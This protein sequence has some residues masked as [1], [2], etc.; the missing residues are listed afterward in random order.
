MYY[1]DLFSPETYEAFNRSSKDVSGFRKQQM[2]MAQKVK[3]GDK[4]V[5]Y[6]T[7]LSRW[8]GILEVLGACYLDASPRFYAEDDPFVVRF[9]VRPLVWL[10][11]EKCVPIHEPFVWDFLSFTKG[12][13]HTSA[14]WTGTIRRSL[15]KLPDEDGRFL[16]KLLLSQ[17]ANG[18]DY[19]V[20]NDEYQKLVLHR[21]RRDDKVVGVTV[22]EDE[23][24]VIPPPP[25]DEKTEVIR[26]SAH[27]QAL[28]AMLGEKMGFTIW[29]PRND[30]A[31]VLH[32]WKPSDGA[33]LDTLP[34]N[35]DEI[36]LQTVER[37]DVLWLKRRAIARAFEV[38]HTTAVYSGILR[39]ADLIALQPNMDIKLHIVAPSIRR[40]KVFSEIQRPV[41]SFLDRGPLKDYCTFIPYDSLVE[42][43]KER[44][45]EHMTDSVLDDVAEEAE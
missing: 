18:I 23:E 15:N 11:K 9:K 6:L 21:V 28:L 44:H 29:L 38:E 10:P 34:L 16:E 42:L 32:E 2:S 7:K 1:T 22:P 41:F 26:E 19:P 20:D 45:L 27:I 14:T 8:V 37:I 5:C 4:F 24:K 33:L 17:A 43:S 25:V 35:Y 30:R 3:P 13:E 31:A 36:T 12:T 40:E 39:M